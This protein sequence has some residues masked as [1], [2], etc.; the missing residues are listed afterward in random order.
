MTDPKEGGDG[1]L[2]AEPLVAGA[3]DLLAEGE[4]IGFQAPDSN[5]SLPYRRSLTALGAER[6]RATRYAGYEATRGAAR[7]T[8][9]DACAPFTRLATR[10]SEAPDRHHGLRR[11]DR[12][13]WIQ[14]AYAGG[15]KYCVRPAAC[16][17]YRS[18]R[19]RTQ[20]H[21]E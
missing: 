7:A 8:V 15:G 10:E 19:R 9:V 20:R 1:A 16:R 18:G 21:W 6:L 3:Q 4:G 14:P 13:R 12:S 17:R 5:A 2:R 11:H